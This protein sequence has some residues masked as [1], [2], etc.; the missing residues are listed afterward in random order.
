M[1]FN[2][3]VAVFQQQMK[4]Q[5]EQHQKQMEA[6]MAMMTTKIQPE[7]T[8][9]NSNIP[10]F[11]SFDPSKELWTDYWSRFQ[12]FLEAHAVPES[13]QAKVFLTN[14]SSV[15]YKL[16][17]N[18]AKQLTPPKDV[19]ALTLEEVEKFMKEQFHPKRFIVL[20]RYKFWSDLKRKPGETIQELIARIRQDAITCDFASIK[21]PL[22]E[23]M[24]TRF[25]CS[26][27]N[28]A[29]LKALFKIKDDELS[30]TRAIEIALDIEDAAKCA[31]ETV[32]G[33]EAQISKIN[34]KSFN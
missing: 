28:E 12:T 19:N 15:N 8:L 34:K 22:D 13:R 11:S 30:F 14:Q 4:D 18:M 27:D 21:Q 3:L 24:R 16:L 32:Y 1:A 29:V 33:E 25:M 20:E 31:K 9:S 26:I 5:Q 6:M 7:T 17:D 2:E 10:S 23:A